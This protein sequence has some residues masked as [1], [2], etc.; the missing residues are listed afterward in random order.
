[1][2]RP[3]H[4]AQTTATLSAG[5]FSE[6]HRRARASTGRIFPLH[7]GDT[8]LDPHPAARAEA[9]RIA[10]WP[11]LHRYAPPPGRPELLDAVQAVM[12]GIA[13]RRLQISC[14]ATG[15]LAVVAGALLDPGDEVILPAPFWP[16][17]RG[18]IEGRGAV[19]RQVPIFD[20]L[21]APDFDLEAALEQ[22]RS[23]RTVAVYVNSPHNPTGR[24]LSDAELGV[25][26]DF[27]R[28]HDLWILSD[29]AYER[30]AYTD[31]PTPLWRRPEL[32]DRVVSAHT[33]SKSHGLSGARIGW[34]QAPEAVAPAV[35]A[36]QTFTTYCAPTPMQ[37]AAVRAL[38]QGDGWVAETRARYARAGA[39]AARA[40]GQPPPQGGTFV[41][42]DVSPWM[43]AGEDLE[44]LLV[45]CLEAGV[46][47]TP[48]TAC[49][50]A[51]TTHVRVSFTSVSE[52]DLE[53]ALGRL[54]EAGVG[55]G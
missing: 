18:I 16:L 39:R 54:K 2:P 41:F 25:F 10:D 51:Y 31:L 28:R 13:R 19:A 32:A 30:L 46:L 11:D 42:A 43:R 20:R 1:M 24:I 35:R 33:L 36:V 12:P 8:T 26:A 50:E 27:A 34:V 53:E 29:E 6:L 47:L 23:P 38:E 9:Q 21:D 49:G 55:H 7:V 52:A 22:A 37:A 14:G 3:P 44:A 45:R 15:G 5:I 48:G 17:I 4:P 40:F